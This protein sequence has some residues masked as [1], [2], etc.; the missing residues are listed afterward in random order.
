MTTR[1]TTDL[2][3]L[4]DAR[5]EN[6]EAMP[7]ARAISASQI[8]NTLLRSDTTREDV[9]NFLERSLPFSFRTLVVPPWAIPLEVSACSGTA[10]GVSAVVGFPHGTVPLSVKLREVE[11]YVSSGVSD[12]DIVAPVYAIRSGD[13]KTVEL[14]IRAL[15]EACGARIFK[16]IIETP[17]LSAEEIALLCDISLSGPGPDFLKTGTG[18]SGKVTTTEHVRLLRER[19]RGRRRIKASG[20]IRT[21]ADALSFLDAGADVIGTSAGIGIL[22][23]QS[24]SSA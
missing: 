5:P 6:P 21:L 9:G 20:G 17:L 1:T 24:A 15:R 18:F 16:L 4:C 7:H 2:I 8:D 13:W 22:G 14:E 3:R 10:C 11:T 12:L 19:L 23:E